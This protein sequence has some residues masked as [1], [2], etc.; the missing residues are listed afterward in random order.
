MTHTNRIITA[1]WA[2][3]AFGKH[4]ITPSVIDQTLIDISASGLIARILPICTC[5]SRGGAP[6]VVRQ[7]LVNVHTCATPVVA[8][9]THMALARGIVAAFWSI[10]TL[11]MEDVASTVVRQALV[12]VRADGV[13]AGL[14]CV[15]ASLT[16]EMASTV[17]GQALIDVNP[18]IYTAE[19]LGALTFVRIDEVYTCTPCLAR[20]RITFIFG[21]RRACRC[22]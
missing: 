1:L 14:I 21:S 5:L 2:I 17:V 7:T 19:T 20:I 11:C 18:T 10:G 22:F 4:R 9:I 8:P 16:C 12:D 6:A 13:V 15:G 3:V